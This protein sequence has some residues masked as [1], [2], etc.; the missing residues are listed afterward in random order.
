[1]STSPKSAKKYR[2]QL[3]IPLRLL[4]EPSRIGPYR[5][6]GRLMDPYDSRYAVA[7]RSHQWYIARQVEPFAPWH[8]RALREDLAKARRIDSPRL[9][10]ITDMDLD[11]EKPWYVHPYP[12]GYCADTRTIHEGDPEDRELRLI[13]LGVAEALADIHA[14]GLV[15]GDI[16]PFTVHLGPEGPQVSDTGLGPGAEQPLLWTRDPQLPERVG[17]DDPVC[18]ASD[19]F[20]WGMLIVF[21]RGEEAPYPGG[22]REEVIQRMAQGDPDLTGLPED[23]KEP[24]RAA[25]HPDPGQ[26]P[27]A[28]RLLEWLTGADGDPEL[29]PR[30]V[31]R[32]ALAD[33]W[34][35]PK[36]TFVRWGKNERP[37]ER[38][39]EM[40]VLFLMVPVGLVVFLVGWLTGG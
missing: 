33:H 12:E 16:S 23:L 5:A 21:L 22:T 6:Q 30:E 11:A 32:A 35:A 27:T 1:M 3:L 38:R 10:P 9:L 20:A 2:P 18:A 25:L 24:V 31:V 17:P 4:K 14:A 13:A 26:R 8:L 34:T 7:D 15:H 40:W 28:A 29:D 37:L 36:D 19:V 39:V